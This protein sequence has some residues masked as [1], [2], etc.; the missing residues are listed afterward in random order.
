MERVGFERGITFGGMADVIGKATRIAPGLRS[1]AIE[2]HWS[3]FRPGT[4]D[5]LPLVG[6][7]RIE[8]LFLASGHYRNGILLA[9]LTAELIADAMAGKPTSREA[10][11]LSPNRFEESVG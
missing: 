5:G 3:S 11:A 10:R 2:E 4:P 1:A 9:P 7:T 8:G 6:G